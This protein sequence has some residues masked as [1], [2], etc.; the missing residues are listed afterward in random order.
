[1]DIIISQGENRI[2]IRND[3]LAK[4]NFKLHNDYDKKLS[5]CREGRRSHAIFAKTEPLNSWVGDA[6]I[7]TAAAVA[8]VLVPG[9]SID[10]HQQETKNW[11]GLA[12][13]NFFGEERVEKLLQMSRLRTSSL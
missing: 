3:K 8:V 7:R 1:M 9:I 6:F 2:K 5:F 12:K 13:M 4:D 11:L 10:D